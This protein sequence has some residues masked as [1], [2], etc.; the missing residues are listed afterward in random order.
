MVEGCGIIL[1]NG[2]GKVLLQL[3]DNKPNIPYPNCLGTFGGHLKQGETARHA[4]IREVRE[5]LGIELSN[6]EYV[7]NYPFEGT[8][9]H[10]FRKLM[11]DLDIKKLNVKEGQAALFVSR[12]DLSKKRFAF[13]CKEILT[14]YYRRFY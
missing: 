11:P 14:D 8:T 10:V 13:N 5:E 4:L 12:D 2:R 6:F 9:V 7:D 1:D 3:R